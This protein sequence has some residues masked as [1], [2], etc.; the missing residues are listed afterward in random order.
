MVIKSINSVNNLEADL[1]PFLSKDRR[2]NFKIDRD[3]PWIMDAGK[4]LD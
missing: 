1:M 2:A 3:F 4:R